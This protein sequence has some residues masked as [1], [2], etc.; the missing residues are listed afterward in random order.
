MA[1]R[2]SCPGN[3]NCRLDRIPDMRHPGGGMAAGRNSGCEISRE[4]GMAAGQN[5]G[6]EISREGGMAAGQNSGCE[7][8]G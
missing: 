4:G 1:R 7:T 2:P 3:M 6:C 8:S 5:S